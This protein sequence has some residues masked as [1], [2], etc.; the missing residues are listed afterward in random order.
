MI[1][2]A[3]VILSSPAGLG[4]ALIALCAISLTI[5]ATSAQGSLL[6]VVDN[7]AS[8]LG[9]VFILLLAATFFDLATTCR[10]LIENNLLQ[11]EFLVITFVGVWHMAMRFIATLD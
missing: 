2:K 4:L 10:I 9:F 7:A 1:E 11:F 6:G 5:R 8:G 3:I